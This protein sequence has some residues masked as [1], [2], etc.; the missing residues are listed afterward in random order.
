MA[1]RQR[2]PEPS[3]LLRTGSWPTGASARPSAR[4]S[5]SARRRQRTAPRPLRRAEARRAQPALRPAARDG[6]ACCCPGP[7]PRARRSTRRE[8]RLAVHVEDHPLEYA[9]LRGRDPRGQLRRRRR[10]RVGPR[11][12]DPARGSRAPG[13]R[14]ASCCSISTATSCAAAGRCSAPKATASKRVAPDQEARRLRRARARR[15]PEQSVLSGRTVEEL[16]DGVDPAAPIR[17]RARAPRRSA[18]RGRGSRRSSRCW[19]SRASAPFSRPGWLFEVKYDGYRMLAATGRRA[20]R[21]CATAAA[22]T[23]RPASPR[24]RDALGALP[25]ERFVARRRGRRARRRRAAELPAP[26]AARAP[27]APRATSRART[28]REPATFFV[29][30]LLGVRGPRP[31]R[32]AARRAQGAAARDRSRRRGRCATATTSRSTA[33]R[34]SRRRAALGLEGIVAKRADSPYRAGARRP[35]SRSAP[36][37]RATSSSSATAAPER[38]ARGLRRAAPR[39]ARRRRARLRRSRRQRLHRGRFAPAADGSRRRTAPDARLHG[40][41]AEGGG[42]RVG[43]AAAACARCATRS[44]PPP[45]CCATRCSCACATT[46]RSRSASA[47]TRRRSTRRATDAGREGAAAP[48]R[49]RHQPRQGLLARRGVHEGRSDRATTARSRRGSCRT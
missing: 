1:K 32:A 24:S 9:R 4:P 38:L 40:R 5:R 47:A 46:S 8:K 3:R 20:G 2:K 39:G 18:A 30:D 48:R 7:C 27:D 49:A 37:A 29:F 16:R 23:R 31:A 21:A 28:R 22:T 43:R 10:D 14:T 12:L 42:A 25:F 19:P 17:A 44:G 13:S 41:P 34:C 6:T 33:R 11:P 15:P 35:G 26:P 45:A 36:I